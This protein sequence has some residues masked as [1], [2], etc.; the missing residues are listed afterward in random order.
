MSNTNSNKKGRGGGTGGDRGG[1]VRAHA[2][3]YC[4]RSHVPCDEGRPCQR[5]IRRRIAHLCHDESKAPPS[6]IQHSQNHTKPVTPNGSTPT[7]QS[8]S[9]SQSLPQNSLNSSLFQPSGIYQSQNTSQS[10]GLGTSLI[11]NSTSL[12]ANSSNL[13]NLNVNLN[14]SNL[15]DM[16]MFLGRNPITSL[17][18]VPPL[19]DHSQAQ[20][21]SQVNQ[22]Q[23]LLQNQ[24]QSLSNSSSD[25]AS[26]L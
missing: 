14:M 11:S 7:S 13:D 23:F 15:G 18:P 19:Y 21:Q 22:Q 3:V 9:Q 10:L 16:D 1:G 4:R 2:C 26:C 8:Q 12:P 17:N 5:C 6:D 20:T 24:T 25:P